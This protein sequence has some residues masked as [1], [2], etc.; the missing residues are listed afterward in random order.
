[1]FWIIGII[2]S[3]AKE[4]ESPKMNALSASEG[5]NDEEEKETLPASDGLDKSIK[6]A[7]I[8]EK[9]KMKMQEIAK[10][11]EN[12]AQEIQNCMSTS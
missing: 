12:Y 1:M 5:S 7:E 11:K 8:N 4:N 9:Y 2:T 3:L 10:V 6:E